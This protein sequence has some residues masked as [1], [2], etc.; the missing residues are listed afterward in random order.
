MNGAAHPWHPEPW[1]IRRVRRDSDDVFTWELAPQNGTA[2]PVFLP[3]QFN[4]IYLFGHGDVAISI[5][6]EGSLDKQHSNGGIL[7]TIHAGGSVTH[8]LHALA[9]GAIVGVRGPFGKSWPVEELRGHDI[10]V[11][12]GGLG[13]APLRALIEWMLARREQYGRIDIVY[14]ART[15]E[16]L[17]YAD[18]IARWQSAPD[19]R[20]HITVDHADA[21]WRGAVGNVPQ[22][23][24]Q[25]TL[26]VAN[27]R[28]VV[29][30]PEIMIKFSA[31]ALQQIGLS[32]EAI[33]VSMERNMQCAVGYCGHCFYGPHFVCKDGPV[34]RFDQLHGQLAIDEL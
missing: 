22:L 18:D 25:I 11:M 3:G 7:H 17:I 32:T 29:C 27:T 12:A 28:A 30:G 23:L 9:A 31:L 19:T 6:G 15:P 16:Q 14:G 8:K 1:Q 21:N 24:S 33:W 26:D 20:V 13:I 34:F 5:C 4:M 2:A 10:V